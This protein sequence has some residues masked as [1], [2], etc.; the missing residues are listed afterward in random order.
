MNS[1]TEIQGMEGET[2]LLQDIFHRVDQSEGMGRLVPT[3]LRPK[4][5]DEL[6]L[7]GIEVPPNVFRNEGEALLVVIAA[8]R[9]PP[10]PGATRACRRATVRGALR[11]TG[12]PP[13]REVSLHVPASLQLTGHGGARCCGPGRRRA[14]HH[15]VG[16]DHAG[17]YKAAHAG[18]RSSTTPWVQ[19]DVPVEVVTESPEHGE[20]S[21][22]TVRI[23]G[24]FGR[25]DTSGALE[26]RLERADIPLRAGEYIVISGAIAFILAVGAGVIVESPFASIVAIALVA[27]IAWYLPSRRATKRIKRYRSSCPTH[28]R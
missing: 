3:G 27:G 20:L 24:I 10:S 2:V 12:A 15:G 25:I 18:R 4:I 5:L 28:W 14:V 13:G 6:A 19:A 17:P 1:I 21:T 7:N 11:D 9:A 23:S 26:R 16:A 8:G 22:L